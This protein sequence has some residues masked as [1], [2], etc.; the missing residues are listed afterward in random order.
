MASGGEDMN[1][2]VFGSGMANNNY[3]ALD[4]GF[5]FSQFGAQYQDANAMRMPQ[6]PVPSNADMSMPAPPNVAAPGLLHPFSSMTLSQPGYAGYNNYIGPSFLQF[7]PRHLL[8]NNFDLVFP[9]F[10]DPMGTATDHLSRWRSDLFPSPS[11]PPSEAM[12]MSE[13][14]QNPA[15]GSD[16]GLFSVMGGYLV[17][18]SPVNPFLGNLLAPPSY[19]STQAMC[20]DQGPGC[21]GHANMTCASQQHQPNG[22][23][24]NPCAQFGKDYLVSHAD[25]ITKREIVEMRAYFCSTCH[26]TLRSG[27]QALRDIYALGTKQVWG[28][29]FIDDTYLEGT[30]NFNGREMKFN[31]SPLPIT[32]C[33]CGT[34]IFGEHLC[35]ADRIKM[36]RQIM[37]QA[38]TVRNWRMMQGETGRCPGC[39]MRTEPNLA[40]PSPTFAELLGDQHQDS[41]ETVSWACLVCGD[42]VINQFKQFTLL[43]LWRRWFSENLAVSDW[44]PDVAES[45]RTGVVGRSKRAAI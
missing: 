41:V 10:T 12:V 5:S 23:V 28:S 40:N 21:N 32:G 34:N 7:M 20:V 25:A 37:Y 38:D 24:C 11:E 18:H 16:F 9:Y 14:L 35:R 19:P 8:Q 31:S 43:P 26:D 42:L 30:I 39:L 45:M 29:Q 1:P 22:P 33:S 27:P 2:F 3:N 17:R 15:G 36:A 44:G 4:N 13:R 6:M